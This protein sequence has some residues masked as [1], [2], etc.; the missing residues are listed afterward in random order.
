MAFVITLNNAIYKIAS[1]ET[2]KNEINIFFPP[3]I[4]HT[5][6]DDQ[7]IKV[8][9]NIAML[10]V[11]NNTVNVTDFDQQNWFLNENS[12]KKYHESIKFLIDAFLNASTNE[13]KSLYT[14][15]QSYRNT[16]DSFDYSSI[17]YPLSVSWE[18]YC[19]QNSITYIHPLQIP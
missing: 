14:V 4:A 11:V 3:A 15:I 16:L 10:S 2:E 7:F 19:E 12:L 5:L 1:N 9:K 6:S 18:Q 13:S 17:T 8:K